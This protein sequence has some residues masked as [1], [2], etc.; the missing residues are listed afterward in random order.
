M[1]GFVRGVNRGSLFL[2]LLPV[3]MVFVLRLFSGLVS[4]MMMFGMLR[5]M[6]LSCVA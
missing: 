2:N 6:L 3:V 5:M 1:S 4:V